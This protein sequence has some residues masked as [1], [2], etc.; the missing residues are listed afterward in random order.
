MDYLKRAGDFFARSRAPYKTNQFGGPRSAVRSFRNK[1]LLLQSII[2]SCARHQ[3]QDQH[4]QPFL[5][6]LQQQG[7]LTE[8]NQ[9]P[10]F[11][12]INHQPFGNQNPSQIARMDQVARNVQAAVFRLPNRPG[13][14]NNYVDNT[15]NVINRTTGRCLRSI[16][17]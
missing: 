2:N 13:L 8:G 17:T 3:G 15:V 16:G 14:A 4:G 6:A 12:P 10:I 11:D 7:I 1:L 5:P 9:G